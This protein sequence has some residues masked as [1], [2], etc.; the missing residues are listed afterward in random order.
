MAFILTHRGQTVLERPHVHTVRQAPPANCLCRCA[1]GLLTRDLTF[2]SD[3]RSALHKVSKLGKQPSRLEKELTN[4]TSDA[5]WN[6]SNSDLQ[7]IASASHD[8]LD[9]SVIRSHVWGVLDDRDKKWR[10]IFKALTLTEILLKYGSEQM[11]EYIKTDLWRIQQWTDHRITENGKDVGAGIRAKANAIVDLCSNPGTLRAVRYESQQLAAKMAIG[12]GGSSAPATAVFKS[13]FE[14]RSKNVVYPSHHEE[15]LKPRETVVE[16]M[17]N[18]FCGLTRAGRLQARDYLERENYNLNGA[19]GQ[20]YA[21]CGGSSPSR[22]PPFLELKRRA[23]VVSSAARVSEKSATELLERSHWDAKDAIDLHS[24]TLRG[25]PRDSSSSSSESSSSSGSRRQPKASPL[26]ARTKDAFGWPP[27]GAFGQLEWPDAWPETAGQG[28]SEPPGFASFGNLGSSFG[29]T[30]S[31]SSAPAFGRSN[32]SLEHTAGTSGPKGS[33][34]GT[35]ATS[36]SNGALVVPPSG[37][38]GG[39]SSFGNSSPG[40]PPGRSAPCAKGK[41]K[42]GGW[43]NDRSSW[44]VAGNP[45]GTSSGS[46][47]AQASLAGQ[48]PCRCRVSPPSGQASWNGGNSPSRGKGGFCSP[49]SGWSSPG[50]GGYGKP[51][52]GQNTP[53]SGFGGQSG[54]NSPATPCGNSTPRVYGPNGTGFG[55]PTG[56]PYGFPCQSGVAFGKGAPSGGPRVNM[57]GGSFGSISNRSW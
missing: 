41:G 35:G 28:N 2:H 46:V 11:L 20:Y 53:M 12:G 1:W 13:P 29:N 36:F 21:E 27:S 6:A 5:N 52:S 26:S 56:S 43:P 19:I 40:T 48:S 17:I 55:A 7:S 9:C 47:P 4:A 34:G 39:P 23:E 30:S 50:K 38:F 14:T 44:P 18:E 3:M 32:Y 42:A 10:R 33:L 57:G 51:G 49:Q 15:L 45:W 24:R 25:P 31:A 8:P 22:K 16:D 54:C 37:S